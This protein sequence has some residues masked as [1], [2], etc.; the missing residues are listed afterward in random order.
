MEEAILRFGQALRRAGIRITVS[1]LQDAL[2]A[3]DEFGL[4]DSHRF[5]C[6]LRAVFVKDRSDNIIFDRAFRLFFLKRILSPILLKYRHKIAVTV[7]M[8]TDPKA[9]VAPKVPVA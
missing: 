9:P 4:E 2:R 1:E 8:A 3:V 7:T 5:Q 6:L